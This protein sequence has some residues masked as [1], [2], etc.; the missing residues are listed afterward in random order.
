M[1]IK[2]ELSELKI[3]RNI[4]KKKFFNFDFNFLKIFSFILKIKN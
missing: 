2:F 3:K 4:K 1:K